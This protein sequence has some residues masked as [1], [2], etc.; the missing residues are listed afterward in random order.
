[1]PQVLA[2]WVLRRRSGR[3]RG[4]DGGPQDRFVAGHEGKCNALAGAWN[5]RPKEYGGSGRA[6]AGRG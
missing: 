6:E 4:G 2:F 3:N 5:H 1:M